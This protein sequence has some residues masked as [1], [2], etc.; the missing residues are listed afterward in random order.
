MQIKP[1]SLRAVENWQPYRGWTPDFT[2]G[3]YPSRL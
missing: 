2:G 3:S 1:K